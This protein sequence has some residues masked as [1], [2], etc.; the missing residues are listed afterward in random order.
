MIRKTGRSCGGAPQFNQRMVALVAEITGLE[1]EPH[2][3]SPQFWRDF[4]G[5]M[6][7]HTVRSAMTKLLLLV[8]V[9]MLVPHAHAATTPHLNL[10]IAIDLTQVGRRQRPDGKTEFQKNVD[11]VTGFLPRFPAGTHVTVI[12]LPTIASPSRTSCSRPPCRTIPDTSAS[13]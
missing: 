2:C 5:S 4:F 3:S 8:V 7:T 1:A 6:L 11:G 10:V 12:G 13:G 9:I